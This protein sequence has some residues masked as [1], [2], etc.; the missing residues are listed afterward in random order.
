MYVEFCIDHVCELASTPVFIDRV[1][2][3]KNPEVYDYTEEC[4]EPSAG[5]V[6][7]HMIE[8]KMNTED[9]YNEA[10]RMDIYQFNSNFKKNVGVWPSDRVKVKTRSKAGGSPGNSSRNRR[11]KSKSNKNRSKSI[12][13]PGAYASD[14]E[15]LN[16]FV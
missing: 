11:S 16:D 3:D 15:D 7:F 5:R 14:D 6:D 9:K 2:F 1:I 10:S 13:S 4:A 8:Y 12:S